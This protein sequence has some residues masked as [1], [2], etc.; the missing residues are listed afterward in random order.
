MR[1]AVRPRR[2]RG[3]GVPAVDAAGREMPPAGVERDLEVGVVRPDRRDDLVGA[4]VEPIEIE[5]EMP[6]AIFEPGAEELTRAL[7][8][9]G[10][11]EQALG[12]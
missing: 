10:G 7:A 11:R 9:G 5:R 6:K 4:A 8:H 12:G 1:G 2:N 3:H